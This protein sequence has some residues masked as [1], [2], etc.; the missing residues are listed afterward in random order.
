M[1]FSLKPMFARVS[2]RLI[3]RWCTLRFD[4]VRR[5]IDFTAL[6]VAGWLIRYPTHRRWLRTIGGPTTLSIVRVYPRIKYRPSTS[7]LYLAAT[8]TERLRML[9]TH[10]GFLNRNHSA[11]FFDRLIAPGGMHL[12]TFAKSQHSFDIAIEGPCRVTKHREGELGLSFAMDGSV[13]YKISFSIVPAAL[14]TEPIRGAG[15]FMLYVGRVQGSPQRYEAIRTAT[16]A[17]HASTPR[18]LLMSAL[19]GVADA[20]GI[21]LIGGVSSE[22][23][24]STGL[25]E[26]ELAFNYNQWW[27]A[28]E[29]RRSSAGHYLIH[30]P[31]RDSRYSGRLVSRTRHKKRLKRAVR[32]AVAEAIV[33]REPVAMIPNDP[34]FARAR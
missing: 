1:T 15:G 9:E 3:D 2:D 12:W 31:E 29:A 8:W 11:A 19:F 21:E 28:Y 14:F 27:E 5:S 33:E 24:L 7:Y 4:L 17:C 22:R 20:W 18:D 34:T 16:A 13:L 32:T 6:R 26:K 23:Q 30:L 25:S 10:Y